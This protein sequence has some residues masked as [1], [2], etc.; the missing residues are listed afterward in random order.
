MK[1]QGKVIIA[2]L[3]QVHSRKK[4]SERVKGWPGATRDKDRNQTQKP[5]QERDR[6]PL[7]NMALRSLRGSGCAA[8]QHPHPV[9]F[10]VETGACPLAPGLEN[11]HMGEVWLPNV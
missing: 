1:Q 10:Q 3:P 7:L 5:K 8:M 6:V 2:L 9:R 11:G 4:E